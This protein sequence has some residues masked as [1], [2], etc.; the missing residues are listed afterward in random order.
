MSVLRS[1]Q[2]IAYLIRLPTGHARCHHAS[3]LVRLG[4]GGARARIQSGRS[5]R[6]R[7]S[8]GNDFRSSSRYN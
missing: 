2:L 3:N 5:R 1:R 8:S 6:S 7:L 4:Q